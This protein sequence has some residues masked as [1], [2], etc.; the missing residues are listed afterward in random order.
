M[1][2]CGFEMMGRTDPVSGKGF[3]WCAQC[4][5]KGSETMTEGEK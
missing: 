4:G 5:H 3:L 2:H 1:K